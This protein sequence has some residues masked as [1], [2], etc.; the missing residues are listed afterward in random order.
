[1][2]TNRIYLPIISGMRRKPGAL[3]PLETSI[4]RACVELRLRG[5]L[6]CHGF[7]LAKEIQDRG[8]AHRLTA[9]GTL[10]KALDRMEKAGL[11]TSR[12]ENPLLAA[13]ERRPRRRLYKATSAGEAVLEK[14]PPILDSHRVTMKPK[15]ATP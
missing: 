13:R 5:I 12:W 15:R 2:L 14:S 10:Y 11:L 4:L 7:L 8:G 9:Y 6:E 1:M 3:F